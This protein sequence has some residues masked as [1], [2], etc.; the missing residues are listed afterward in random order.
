MKSIKTRL[1][2][3]FSILI[4]ISSIAIG[5]TSIQ[6]ASG[7]IIEVAEES[8]GS[9]TVEGTRLTESRIEIQKQ[10]MEIIASMEDIEGMEWEI[11]KPLLERQAKRT[12]FLTLGIVDLNGKVQFNDGTIA[13]VADKKYFK[14]ALNGN[15]SISDVIISKMTN[16]PELAYVAPIESSGRVVGVLMGIRD[17]YVVTDMIEGIGFGDKGYSYIVNGE[18]TVV[19]HPNREMVATQFNPI[20]DAKNNASIQSTADLVGK[21]LGRKSGVDSYLFNGNDLYAA[22]VPIEGSEWTMVITANQD[23]VLAAI[24]IMKKTVLTMTSII[25][26]V[27][28]VTTYIIGNSISKP[29]I[30]VKEDAEKLAK[31]DITQD[32]DSRLLNQK[33][34]I[35]IL[36]R[37]IQSVI[38]NLRAIV[39]EINQ[40]SDQVAI[41]SEE[42]MAS[43]QQSSAAV[44]EVAMAVDE[45]ARGAA[46]QAENTELGYSKASILGEIIERDQVEMK[47][48]N[49]A[50]LK[51]GEAVESGLVEIE[52]LTKITNES[53]LSIQGIREAILKTNESSNKIGQASNVI[54]SIAEQT[55]LLA[56][57]A[58][59]EAA[60]AGE[61]GRGFAV[62]ADEIRK[63]AE[64][65]SISTKDIDEVVNELQENAKNAVQTVERVS[66]IS[67][68]QSSS[69]VNSRE[70][71]MI[72][73][74]S[75]LHAEESIAKLNVSGQEMYEMKG[76]IL[77][78]IQ[79]LSAIA[80]ENSA[81]TQ[82]V[83]ASMEEQAA[84]IEE[85]SS[86]SEG[87]AKL[88]QDLHSI[89]LRFK[90]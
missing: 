58:A 36:A 5:F 71:F 35:G 44:D 10:A 17:G 62:V 15:T 18:G 37:S 21:T 54:A 73:S 31:L 74:E 11:Q 19:A 66:S 6:R 3:Y 8:L 67:A 65:S 76:E 82:E 61:V 80:E 64:Q 70:K 50:S 12:G 81:S 42:L 49:T 28:I 79:N 83:S 26:M 39:H 46:D 77:A 78:T 69:V 52:N 4:L 90:I 29:I 16:E 68:E 84:S 13:N 48:V 47:E 7:S 25:L 89:I 27:S 40:S 2:V 57:N 63:L 9:L 59:I 88:A 23:E 45:V 34:E 55:N 85:I 14:D 38:T 87:L 24:P 33:D 30:K 75:M 1:V 43:S 20:E 32:V 22:Y 53:S 41:A 60:R 56:L 51:V 72:I 86:A